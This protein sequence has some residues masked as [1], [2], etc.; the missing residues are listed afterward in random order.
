MD[1]RFPERLARTL[2]VLAGVALALVLL[3]LAVDSR[4]LRVGVAVLVVTPL[5]ALAGT[6]ATMLRSAPR[7]GLT[8][9]LTVAIAILGALFGGR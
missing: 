3:G 2:A 7:V 6:G 9:L 5:V 8:A 1:S 4:L